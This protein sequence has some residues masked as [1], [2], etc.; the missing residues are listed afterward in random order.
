MLA[1]AVRCGEWLR[2]MRRVRGLEPL[3]WASA[4][5][6]SGLERELLS[7]ANATL[8]RGMLQRIAVIEAVHAGSGLLLFDEPFSGLD[9]AGRQWLG[10]E[11]Q[12]CVGEGA[13][14][15]LTDHADAP[16]GHLRLTDVVQV[17]DGTCQRRQ[18]PAAPADPA[19]QVVVLASHDDGRRLQRAAAA[20]A[21]DELLGSLLSAGWH[22]VEVRPYEAECHTSS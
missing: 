19:P 5:V 13:C 3:D 7:R 10:A 16:G 8:S 2:A 18:L 17:G 9:A 11:I 21:V 1:A 20:P 14:V 12:R 6:A 4:V 22:I 15:V